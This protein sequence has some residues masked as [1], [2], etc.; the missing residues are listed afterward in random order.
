VSPC[1]RQ[2]WQQWLVPERP[3]LSDAE[4]VGNQ[5]YVFRS[6]QQEVSLK[7]QSRA[8]ISIYYARKIIIELTNTG[9]LI[10]P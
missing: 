4:E 8:K 2:K 6:I 3:T 5:L 1:Q 7:A 10:D 9:S